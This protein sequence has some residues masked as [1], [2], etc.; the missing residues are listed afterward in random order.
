MPDNS[1]INLQLRR[2]IPSMQSIL[3]LFA[4]I[5]AAIQ[6]ASNV[7]HV[8]WNITVSVPKVNKQILQ[9]VVGCSKKGSLHAILGPSGITHS[10]TRGFLYVHN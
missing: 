9:S 3:L 2:N 1:E 4:G 5:V 8:Y 6:A 7:N 10:F